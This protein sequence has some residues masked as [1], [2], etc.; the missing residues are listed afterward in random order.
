MKK[1]TRRTRK[2][3]SKDI[4]RCG[5]CGNTKN[6]IKTECCNNWICDDQD[7]YVMFS[8]ARNS[9]SRN[10]DRYTLCGFHFNEGH[11]GNWQDCKKCRDAF[12][13]EM[14]V[15]NGTNEYNFEKLKNPPAFEP[16][17]CSKCNE[18]IIL[19]DGGYSVQGKKYFCYDCTI[20][21]HPLLERE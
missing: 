15:Y 4:P 6:L 2:S 21:E 16:T 8:Y 7:E 18:I 1:K 11:E 10:H 9:C 17:R 12:E 13:P 3:I 5:L 19:G 14:Y 20:E